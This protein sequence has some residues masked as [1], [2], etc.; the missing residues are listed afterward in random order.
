[1]RVLVLGTGGREHAL[2]WA[3]AKSPL[4]EEVLCAPGSDGIAADA[5]VLSLDAA[6]PR[7]L[8]EAVKH[9]GISLVVVGPED[10]LA[11]GI[12]DRLAEA[13]IAVFGPSAEAARL[14]SSKRFAKEFM[15]RHG[16]PTGAFAS[17]TSADEAEAYVRAR[18]GACVVKADG[19]AAGKGV[20]VCAGPDEALRALGEIMRER[21]FGASGAEVVIEERLEGE[22]ASFYALCDGERFLV[23]SHAQDHKRIFDGDRGENTGGMGAYSPAG[24][25]DAR[26]ER[27]IVDTIV[28][29]TFDGMRAEGRPFRGVLF[30]GLM[31]DAGRPRVI[32][33]NARF[34]DPETQALLFRL[35]SDL[36]PL[37]VGTAEGR[38]AENAPPVLFGDP[39]V[40]VVM[41]SEGYPR[42]STSGVVIRGLET[43]D[44][45]SDAKVFHSGT[46]RVGGQ[47]QTAGG[48]VLGVTARGATLE[49]ARARAYALCAGVTFDGA[50]Y[51]RDIG[52]RAL[53]PARS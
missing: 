18:G 46:R 48:R 2:V 39:A 29:P 42:T 5:R 24:P 14:E 3:I 26:L 21:R 7:A 51:R 49:A 15:A 8:V 9:E 28:R 41:A 23:L 25:V 4:V 1:M 52:G 44:G 16:I 12:A 34:G 50:Q 35:E 53:A 17:F 31:I 13:G 47:W 20:T 27:E 43:L 19:L 6:D 22:E 36:V 32:E 45:L 30:V 33:Y 40:C 37:L 10:L 38:L 11:A